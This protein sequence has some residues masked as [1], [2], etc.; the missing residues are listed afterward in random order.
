MNAKKYSATSMDM[1]QLLREVQSLRVAIKKTQKQCMAQWRPHI[2][3]RSFL[4]SASNLAAYL[5]LR[6]HDLRQMQCRLANLG[7]S[8]LGRSEAHV[9]ASL[10]AITHILKVISGKSLPTEKLTLSSAAME[11]AEDFLKRHTRQLF[12]PPPPRRWARIMVTFPRE[13][14]SD[15]LFVRE[16]VVRGMDCARINCAHDDQASWQRMVEFVHQAEQETGRSCKILMD[17]AGPKL[18]TGSVIPGPAVIHLKPKRDLSGNFTQATSV[19]LDG[20]G[21]PGRP[22]ERD[23]LGRRA[24]ARLA[25]GAEWQE[26]LQH[27]DVIR[28]ADTRNRQ[29][30][31]IVLNRISQNEVMASCDASA[32]LRPGLELEYSHSKKGAP[33]LTVIGDITSQPQPIILHQGDVLM[34]TRAPT[35]GEPPKMDEDGNTLIPAHI[36]CIQPEVFNYLKPGHRVWIDDGRIGA[37]LESLNDEGALLRIIRT[38]QEGEKLH[39]G[40]GLNFPDSVLNFPALTEKDLHDLDFVAVHADMVG[41]SFVQSADDMEQLIAELA[42][43]GGKKIGIVAKIETGMGLRNLPE[44]I[45]RGAGRHS[46]GVMIARGDLAVEIG[47]ARMAEI[48]EEILWLCEAAHVPVIWATQVLEGLVKQNFPSRAEMTDAAMANRAECIMLNKGPF[49]LDAIEVLDNVVEKMQAHQQKK[50]SQ[51]RALHW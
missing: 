49:V 7:L 23:G 35:P 42:A 22:A 5:G 29:C 28:F 15:Y 51:L 8:S 20:S 17:L 46:F 10:D 36:S 19:V 11:G 6:R 26:R 38:R 39:P 50:T 40:K 1:A 21:N 2:R 25:V 16:L 12:G 27:G 32:Y 45:I 41:Y 34:L 24:P 9:L 43:R 31:L 3:Q 4:A 18:R 30:E 37:M 47:Y 48:Q 44:I 14:A 33:A 13:A